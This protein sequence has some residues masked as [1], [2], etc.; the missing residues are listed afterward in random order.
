MSNLSAMNLG[1]TEPFGPDFAA[2]RF[3]RMRSAYLSL[4]VDSDEEANRIYKLLTDGGVILHKTGGGFCMAVR[5]GAKRVRYI[6]DSA[7]PARPNR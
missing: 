4:T 6:V 2:D 1:G 5:D 3:R 7:S